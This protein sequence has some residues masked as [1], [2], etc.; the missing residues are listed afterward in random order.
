MPVETAS[1]FSNVIQEHLE[2]KRRNAGLDGDMPLSRYMVDDP[3][4]N[5][6]LFKSE[7]QARREDTLDGQSV[8]EMT[9]LLNAENEDT[10]EHEAL[11]GE[12]V[13]APSAAAPAPTFLTG[14]APQRRTQEPASAPVEAAAAAVAA[15]LP[16]AA[17]SA[18]SAAP[19]P[20]TAATPAAD[21]PDGATS[22]DAT[23]G[24]PIEETAWGTSRDFDWGD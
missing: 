19:A 2:L 4:S 3:F 14:A 8:G 24:L 9:M 5:H 13:Q 15:P 18:A 12:S 6:P 22:L 10:A 17:A 21:D 20:V 7:E 23:A 11:S 16:E 1:L